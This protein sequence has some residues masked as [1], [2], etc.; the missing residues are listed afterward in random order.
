MYFFNCTWSKDTGQNSVP[1]SEQTHKK[2]AHM[3]PVRLCQSCGRRHDWTY[4]CA[5]RIL[6][7]LRKQ[8]P[9]SLPRKPLKLSRKKTEE[10]IVSEFARA[11]R[12]QLAE[13]EDMLRCPITLQTFEYPVRAGD[14]NT[15]E[16]AAIRAW[17]KGRKS[18]PLTRQNMFPASLRVDERMR[19]SL[20]KLQK[21]RKIYDK[22]KRGVEPSHTERE[23]LKLTLPLQV[24]QDV[25]FQQGVDFVAFKV[26]FFG[27]HSFVY[28]ATAATQADSIPADR[29][30]MSVIYNKTDLDHYLASVYPHC[31]RYRVSL[32][33]WDKMLQKKPG[34]QLCMFF[35]ESLLHRGGFAPSSME[36]VVHMALKRRT[37]MR[38]KSLQEIQ[39]TFSIKVDFPPMRDNLSYRVA[40][41][42][43]GNFYTHAP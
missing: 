26:S 9:L 34:E 2:R 22:I 3:P 8:T 4:M 30:M 5:A 27:K 12:K 15:Y 11:L 24:P 21:K 7:D 16:E 29:S 33:M 38:R 28:L 6:D 37:H 43:H 36:E 39:P 18:S 25:S 40:T 17:L 13:E 1:V 41:T 31:Q 35:R 23:A 32:P 14:N 19:R 42:L 10:V 20:A